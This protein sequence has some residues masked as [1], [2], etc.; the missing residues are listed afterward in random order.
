MALI[1]ILE[2]KLGRGFT[3]NEKEAW[4]ALHQ[5]ISNKMKEGLDCI[6]A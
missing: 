5:I 4:R 3:P 2:D 1:S 6:D